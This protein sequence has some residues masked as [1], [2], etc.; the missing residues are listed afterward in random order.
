MVGGR[1]EASDDRTGTGG[2]LAQ[3]RRASAG[4]GG[5]VLPDPV[6]IGG[7]VFGL[8][9]LV[10]EYTGPG[11]YPIGQLSG[12]GTDF[13]IVIGEARYQPDPEGTSTAELTVEADGSG[14]LRASGFTID[15]GS[16]TLSPP[17]DAEV[18]WT[19]TDA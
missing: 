8:E 4:P 3:A 6:C 17:A 11:T 10:T 19:C 5:K 13:T 15:D 14:S 12:E 2:D 18:T 16:G 7:T 1:P 9:S